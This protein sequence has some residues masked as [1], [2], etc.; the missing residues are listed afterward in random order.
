[1]GER[2]HRP[3]TLSS[4]GTTGSVAVEK[5]S[6]VTSPDRTVN[7]STKSTAVHSERVRSSAGFDK[8][9][10]EGQKGDKSRPVGSGG[11]ALGPSKIFLVSI[12]Q[13]HY[14]DLNHLPQLQTITISPNL[15]I[16]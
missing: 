4:L 16:L 1:M 6:N 7:R 11:K 8:F 13:Q 10:P 14:S 3:G 9:L 12:F 15:I 5:M 2:A